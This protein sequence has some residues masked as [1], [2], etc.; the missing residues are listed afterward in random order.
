[1]T[2]T[3]NQQGQRTRMPRLLPLADF[4]LF[5]IFLR[6]CQQSSQALQQLRLQTGLGDDLTRIINAPKSEIVP[7]CHVCMKAVMY[8][9][10]YYH[11]DCDMQ[12][13][14]CGTWGTA[15]VTNV[16]PFSCACV[17]HIQI[18]CSIAEPSLLVSS[19]MK[20]MK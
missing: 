16:P 6:S 9:T 12:L 7:P 18:A 10:S 11:N 13:R 20:H 14:S 3:V 19:R 17:E 1:M 15:A 8:F 4:G 2:S 5:K